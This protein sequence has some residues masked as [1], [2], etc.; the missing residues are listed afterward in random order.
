MMYHVPETYEKNQEIFII[1]Y[2][3]FLIKMHVSHTL[4]L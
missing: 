1:I 2:I 4:I 3:F